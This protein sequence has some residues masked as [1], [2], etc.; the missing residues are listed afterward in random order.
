MS[1]QNV[2]AINKPDRKGSLTTGIIL[3]TI[4]LGMLVSRWLPID[5]L[6]PLALGLGFII[7][8]IFKRSAGLLIPGGI[9]GGVGLAI[10]VMEN[11]WFAPM[12]SV[13]GGGV[14]LVTMSLGWFAIIVL[15]RLFTAEPQTW[16]IFPGLAMA[17]IGALVLMGERGL[18]ILEIASAYWPL[19]LVAVGLSI[20]FRSWKERQ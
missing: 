14:F 17:L 20:L 10:L 2:V 18:Q 16:P 3:I 19:I 5:Y 9:I 6:F 12:G 8:G 1:E 13:A 7:A 4:G 15:S 11:N